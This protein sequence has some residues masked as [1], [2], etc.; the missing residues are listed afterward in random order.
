MACLTQLGA[1]NQK[2]PAR[3][4]G[5][6]SLLTSAI[7]TP[8]ERKSEVII[9]LMKRS[10]AEACATKPTSTRT[11]TNLQFV[12]PEFT[13]FLGHLPPAPHHLPPAYTYTGNPNLLHDLP[14]LAPPLSSW[15]SRTS[16]GHV[17]PHAQASSTRSS[18]H[19]G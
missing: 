7:A 14:P 19:P 16:P 3:M 4:S 17:H 10:C 5:F 18:P 13:D 1:S 6:P 15:R 11:E 8:S 9:C 2:A 12:I